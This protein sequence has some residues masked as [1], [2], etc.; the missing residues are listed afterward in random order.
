MIPG[1]SPSSLC[2]SLTSSLS[3]SALCLLG[4][5]AVTGCEWWIPKGEP[6]ATYLEPPE[7]QETLEEVTHRL[8]QWP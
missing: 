8:H 6:P 1:R 2:V 7:M 3:L 5:V 4:L